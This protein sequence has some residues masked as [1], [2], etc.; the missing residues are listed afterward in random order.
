MYHLEVKKRAAKEIAAL[1]KKD[2]QRVLEALD[3]LRENPFVGKKL[4]GDYQGSWSLR[5]WPYR[6]IY[7]IDRKVV[8]VWVLRVKHRQGAYK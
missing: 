2:K 7:L 6:I 8:T 4:E 1:Q 3:T 5:V